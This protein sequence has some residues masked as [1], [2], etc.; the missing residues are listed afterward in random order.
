MVYPVCQAILLHLDH[1]GD[2]SVAHLTEK[3]YQSHRAVVVLAA[4]ALKAADRWLPKYT[5]F[6]CQSIGADMLLKGHVDCVCFG[7]LG[8]LV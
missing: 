1:D 6:L 4:Q 2:L 7:Q 3:G 5:Y 8:R